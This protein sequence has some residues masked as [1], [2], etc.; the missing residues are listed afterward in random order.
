MVRILSCLVVFAS[1]ATST[2]AL[3]QERSSEVRVLETQMHEF[4]AT[5]GTTFD[6]FVALPRDYVADGSVEYPV[7]YMIDASQT[8]AALVQ[9]HRFMAFNGEL[10]PMILVGVDR[11]GVSWDEWWVSRIFDLTPT[12]NPDTDSQL[13]EAFEADVTSGGASAFFAALED[14]IIPWVETRYA[15]GPERGVGGYS[16]GGLFV[17]NALLSS[18]E[19]FTHYLVG[20]PSLFWD[21]RVMFDRELAYSNEFDNLEARVF[22]SAGSQEGSLLRDMLRMAEVLEARA[23]PGLELVSQTLQDETHMSGAFLSLARGLRSLFG[24]N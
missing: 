23:Y 11:A 17:L 1:A 7:F 4:R 15:V 21:D 10:P 20:S 8:F 13:S 14:E 16:L 19:V 9:I 18:P 6:L 3:A 24:A 2:A 22:M 12:S 5:D